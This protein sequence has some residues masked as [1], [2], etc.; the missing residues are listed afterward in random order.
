[1]SDSWPTLRSGCHTLNSYSC[2]ARRDTQVP[3]CC[4][5]GYPSTRPQINVPGMA[6]LTF[7]GHA[8]RLYSRTPCV[9]CTRGHPPAGLPMRYARCGLQRLLDVPQPVQVSAYNATFAAALCAR[10]DNGP[11]R[12]NHTVKN[13]D[14]IKTMLQHPTGPPV[15]MTSP[16]GQR[17]R[18]GHQPAG[19]SMG[20]MLQQPTSP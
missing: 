6:G 15:A 2:E 12:P 4:T 14:P 10:K 18:C 17:T 16:R 7:G 5:H 13:L 3:A 1:L 8:T 19:A 11:L 20:S 9:A